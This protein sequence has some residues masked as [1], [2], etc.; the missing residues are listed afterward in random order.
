MLRTQLARVL[1]DPERKPPGDGV[2]IRPARMNDEERLRRFLAGLSLRT[3]TLRFFTGVSRPSASMVRAM[4]AVDGRRDVLLAVHEDVVVGH[5]M[6]F[7][8]SGSDVEIAL[9]VAD[10]WQGRGIGSR[11]ARRLLR[12]AGASGAR[13]LGMDVLC[14]NRTVLSMVRR[15]WPEATMKATSGTVEVTVAMDP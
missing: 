5:A 12:R 15:A 9:V 13:T 14:E 7:A 8:G 11:L 10:E 4:I 2:E 3:Q 1:R 6:S